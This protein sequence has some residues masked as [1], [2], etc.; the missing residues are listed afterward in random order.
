M[1]YICAYMYIFTHACVDP[2]SSSL[3]VN[4]KVLIFLFLFSNQTCLKSNS[5]TKSS[6][7]ISQR[8]ILCPSTL[9]YFVFLVQQKNPIHSS[10]QRKML[11]SEQE[12]RPPLLGPNTA[13]PPHLVHYSTP[14]NVENFYWKKR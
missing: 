7:E 12:T 5:R 9:A 10:W 1:F 13:K 11:Q 14:S 6:P 4:Q 8:F 2:F 3:V